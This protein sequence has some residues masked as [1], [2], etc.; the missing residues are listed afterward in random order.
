[1]PEAD[2]E[3]ARRLRALRHKIAAVPERVIAEKA[4]IGRG[5]IYNAL[6]AGRAHP[7]SWKTTERL[8]RALGGDPAEFEE[9]W[10][11]AR[12]GSVL[13]PQERVRVDLDM[14]RADVSG[15]LALLSSEMFA[16]GE[17]PGIPVAEYRFGVEQGRVA[18]WHAIPDCGE[19]FWFAGGGEFLAG[20]AKHQREEHADGT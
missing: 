2:T 1:M 3:L 9:L 18:A 5:N 4:G 12:D 16:A 8:I 7:P 11:A 14:M 17:I 6:H 15:M 19:H 10:R 20:A 13:T